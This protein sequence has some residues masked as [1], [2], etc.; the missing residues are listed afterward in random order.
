MQIVAQLEN[1]TWIIRLGLAFARNK[2]SWIEIRP[3]ATWTNKT[4]TWPT[5][6]Q[7]ELKSQTLTALSVL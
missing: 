5:Q 3:N 4:K 2:D 7:I 6:T 1:S